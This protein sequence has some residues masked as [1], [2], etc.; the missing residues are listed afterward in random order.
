ME[1][2]ELRA[3]V[4]A[5]R[6]KNAEGYSEEVKRAVTAYAQARRGAGL[7]WEDIA[8]ET[9]LSA[10][11]LLSWCKQKRRF[12]P[13][14]ITQAEPEAAAVAPST[15]VPAAGLVLH[16]PSGFRLEGLDLQQALAL[17]EVLR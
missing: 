12:L 15:P 4:R 3:L 2:E 14:A 9:G 11:T 6:P 10:S 7:R 13:V 1:Q 16:T 17:L 8:A 5:N